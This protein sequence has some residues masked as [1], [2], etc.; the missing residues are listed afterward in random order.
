M[1]LDPTVRRDADLID[2]TADG[3]MD[4]SRTCVGTARARVTRSIELYGL[5]LPLLVGARKEVM[6]HIEL[7]QTNL[8]DLLADADVQPRPRDENQ[9]DGYI[10]MLRTATLPSSPYS[11]AARTQLI[12]MGMPQLCA[13]VEDAIAAP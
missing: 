2:V 6:R 1:L 3:R 9:V 11:K 7:L 5:N 10:D 4:R 13:Q 12:L 8:I